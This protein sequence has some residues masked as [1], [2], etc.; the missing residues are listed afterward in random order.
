MKKFQI[1]IALL[2]FV[3]LA[4]C[5]GGGNSTSGS[6]V[7]G[8]PV[9]QSIQVTPST[10]SIASGLSQQFTAT[11]NYS[12]NSSKNLTNSAT[13]SSS[14]T[15]IATVSSVGAA[16]G[17]APGSASITATVSG[18]SGSATLTVTAPALVSLAVSP[19]SASVALGSTVQFTATGTFTD[20]ST[21]NLTTSVQWSS[22]NPAVAGINANGTPGL[23][24]GMVLGTSS[25]SAA[26]GSIS[27]S[28]TLSVTNAV[29][30]SLAVTPATVSIAQ[31]TTVQFAA[32]GTFTDG[33]TQNLTTFVQWASANPSVAGI[34]V[35]GA[36]GLAKG[37]A[38]GVA[39]ITATSGSVSSSAVLTVT[40]ATLTSIAV[41]PANASLPLGT[42]QQ[43]TATGTFSDGSTQDVTG[44]VTWSSS[45][46]SVASITVS[47]LVTARNLGTVTITAAS[48]SIN[49]SASASVNAADLASLRLP[50][51]MSRLL[52]PPVSS[53]LRL[54]PSMT[55]A[56]AT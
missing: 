25:I 2:Y 32:T 3:V 48:G 1:V 43:F 4:G 13:W 31:G 12:D 29:L 15:G 17:K 8:A 7:P 51:A 46:T 22:T 34:N 27:A 42:L 49:G 18:V 41:T 50:R 26:S 9:L 39:N 5:G 53:F 35:N 47:G 45:N 55:E 36:P 37:L 54:A 19:A 10:P 6:K 24:V 21:Q 52:Q 20:G 33:T 28:S 23:A 16:T 14:N 11:G 40:N 44:I 38:P 56:R 30:S